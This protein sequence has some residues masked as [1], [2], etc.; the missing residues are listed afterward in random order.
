[1]P[2]RNKPDAIRD[3]ISYDTDEFTPRRSRQPRADETYW[4][5]DED[6]R[7][8]AAG[9]VERELEKRRQAGEALR[10]EVPAHERNL[11]TTFWG[12]SWNRN[13][14]SYSDY[15]SRMPRGRTIFRSGKVMDLTIAG[16]RI[17]SLVAGSHLYEVQIR[18]A[19]LEEEV[20]AA[21]KKKC[22]G[23]V[24]GLVELL[25]GELS[26]EVMKEV[27]SR[28]G[29]LFPSPGEL[30]LGCTCPDFAGLCKHLAAT[31]Y[32]VGSRLD[33]QPALVFTLRGVDPQELTARDAKEAVAH[34]TAPAGVDPRRAAALEGMDLTDVFGL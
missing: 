22:Q 11:S 18:V 7:W 9:R 16:G 10:P 33:T 23:K 19:P 17:T 27:T 15:E 8:A 28:E 20:W 14:M 12:Q 4:H 6:E 26:D 5:Q 24:G 29:G 30:K 21:L 3:D 32:A 34:L 1:M 31:L 2:A 25:S 13:L